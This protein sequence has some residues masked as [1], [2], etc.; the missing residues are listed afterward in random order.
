MKTFLVIFAMI[1]TTFGAYAA[2]DCKQE[3]QEV[4]HQEEVDLNTDV[5]KGMEGAVIIVRSKD[6]RESSVPIEKFKVVPRKQQLMYTKVVSKS[7][8]ICEGGKN[9]LM[10]GARKDYR[11]TST[12]T[13]ADGKTASVS[14]EKDLVPDASYMRRKLFGPIGAGVGIDTNATPRV[15]FGTEW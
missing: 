9:L 2:E 5:P 13:S 12:Q 11:S 3:V 4:S 15:F 14:T 7:K 8:S 6:G 1:F 10:F